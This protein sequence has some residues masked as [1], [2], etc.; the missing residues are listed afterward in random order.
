[1]VQYNFTIVTLSL[2]PLSLIFWF[3][4]YSFRSFTPDNIQPVMGI[5]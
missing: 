2:L 1:M 4:F 3:F 5:S